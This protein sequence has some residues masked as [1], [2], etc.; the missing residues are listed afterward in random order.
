M[1]IAGLHSPN[2]QEN[3]GAKHRFPHILTKLFSVSVQACSTERIFFNFVID[4]NT[5]INSNPNKVF[6]NPFLNIKRRD[7]FIHA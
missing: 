5:M 1:S 2:N 4:Q 6:I 3:K 7:R